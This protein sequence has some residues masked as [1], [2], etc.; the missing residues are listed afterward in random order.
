MPKFGVTKTAA[1]CAAAA[2]AAA[3]GTASAT[4]ATP[5][6]TH[7]AAQRY[8]DPVLVDCLWKPQERPADFMLACGDGNSRLTSLDWSRWDAKSAVA[9]G[10]NVVNDCEPYCAAG[11]FHSYPV[12]V[13]LDQP[14]PWKKHPQLR[15]YTRMTLTYTDDRPERLASVVTYPLG[16]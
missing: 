12:V 5:S 9:K 16:S 15:H 7:S 13:R 1:L 4:P 3:L 11:T 10:R 8:E 2:F 14:E 6:G